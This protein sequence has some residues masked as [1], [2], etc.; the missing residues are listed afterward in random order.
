[1]VQKR[2]E[3]QA[4]LDTVLGR[5]LKAKQDESSVLE[6]EQE[7]ELHL[8]G[9]T[10]YIPTYTRSVMDRH[11]G[12]PVMAVHTRTDPESKS[13]F[14]YPAKDPKARDAK[15]LRSSDAMG[16]AY[17]AFGVPLRK[18]KTRLNITR[19]VILPLNILEVQGEG[20]IY[21]VSFADIVKERRDVDLEAIA[22]AKQKKTLQR[23]AR[24]GTGQ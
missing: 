14:L 1:M 3:D 22:A 6:V 19:R 13:V 15:R 10:A 24:Q 18:L 8:V 7:L 2:S 4:P 17:L 16:A 9:T 21:W 12:S 20:V 5:F 11:F 23:K